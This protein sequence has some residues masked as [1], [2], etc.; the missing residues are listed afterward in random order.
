MFYE[1][2]EEDL[3][4]GLQGV[5]PAVSAAYVALYAAKPLTVRN[6]RRGYHHSSNQ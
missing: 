6:D 3:Q 2:E 1:F 4:E 5:V